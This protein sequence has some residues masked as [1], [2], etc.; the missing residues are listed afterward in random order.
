[1]ELR[2]LRYFIGA[3]EAGSLLKASA[4]LHVAQPA[5]SQQVAALEAEV[6]AKL[7]DRSSRG[8]TLTDAGKV[9]LVHAQVVLADLERARDAVREV[10]SVPRGEV[11]VGL[12]TT[13]G[14][15]ATLPVLGA[16]RAQ[17]P[18]V[19][20]KVVEAYSGFLR[21]WLLSGRLDVAVLFGDA[22]EPG[23]YKEVLLDEWLVFVTGPEGPRLPKTLALQALAQWPLVLPGK[24]HGLRRII[25]EACA[26]HGVELNVVAEIESLRS[27]KLAAQ[28]G[29]GATILPM[30]AV[31]EEVAAGQL[32]SAR[33]DSPA[34]TR[35]VVCATST[36]RPS[37]LARSAV[38][39][40][41]VGVVKD[42]VR[43]GAWPARRPVDKPGRG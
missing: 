26:P 28:H 15:T 17:L 18:E 11:A 16:C 3:A 9:F 7:F 6:G 20:L 35:R 31:A 1:M 29:L 22:P 27:V 32:R 39:S 5:L 19:R 41:L 13:V 23:L 40:I 33:L 8:V 36:S 24:E 42:M 21:E 4:R 34:M 25:D 14:L 38:H 37:T 10:H 2:Q 43:S 12:P 30:A